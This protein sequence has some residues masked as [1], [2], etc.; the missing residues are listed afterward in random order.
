[1]DKTIA[2]SVCINYSD[3]LA[4]TLPNNR[5]LF[6]KYYIIT[7]RSD[8]ETIKLAREYDC[9]LLFS[10]Q[11][12]ANGASFN[13]SGMIHAAQH[14]VHKRHTSDWIVILDADI[15]LPSDIWKN[16]NVTSLNKNGLYGISRKTYTTYSDY[17][18]ERVSS[19]DKCETGVIGYFQLYWNK[20]KYY[21]PWS[22]N[23][24]KCDITFMQ[25]FRHVRAFTTIYCFHFGEKNI[26]WNGRIC[27]KWA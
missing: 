18:D 10:D 12:N 9:V 2:I 3:Y 23:C 24:S 25:L 19:E 13:K 4:Q 17:I 14:F 26:N 11:K 22:M 16:I 15:F 5:P 1:M 7:E 6:S 20:S 27:T 8:T 21:T